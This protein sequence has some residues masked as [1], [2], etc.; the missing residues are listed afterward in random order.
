MDESIR[1]APFSNRYELA[2]KEFLNLQYKPLPEGNRHTGDN[3]KTTAT[4][5]KTNIFV[6]TDAA[7]SLMG[8]T[9][10]IRSKDT[11]AG[12]EPHGRYDNNGT[13]DRA[14]AFNHQ[15]SIKQLSFC[16]LTGHPDK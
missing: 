6:I 5:I 13:K 3:T 2:Q 15:S 10:S 7:G 14:S 8:T 9:P 1:A 16:T 4:Q 12:T 11:L